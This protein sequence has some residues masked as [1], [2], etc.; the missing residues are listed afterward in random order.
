MSAD[1]PARPGADPDLAALAQ[2][3]GM[4][5]VGLRPGLRQYLR[6]LYRR[7]DFIYTL[8][9]SGIVSS[10]SQ[11]R[12]GRIWLVLTPLLQGLVYGTIFG[13]LLTTG[14]GID[15]FVGYLMVGIFLFQYSARALTEGAKAVTGNRKLVQVL[16]FPRAALPL[17]LTLRNMLSFLPALLVMFVVVLLAPTAEVITWRWALFLPI[18]LLLS[19]F[20][21]GLSFLAA[22]AVASVADVSQIIPFA[23]RIWFYTSGV[24]FAYDRFAGDSPELLAILE[25]NPMHVFLTLARDALL[26]G[27]DSP[28][29]YWWQAV[30]WAFGLA[31]VGFVV[32]W[33]AEEKYTRD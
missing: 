22:R 28:A 32:F 23:L 20:N 29:A 31:L 16:S 17:S 2:R 11:N 14:R 8:A 13:V 30:A 9:R 19:L 27:Q 7:R 1:A 18:V 33:L 24:F 3:H 4:S 10:S 25:A 6:Q 5:V 21:L 26:Y 12:L 15:N